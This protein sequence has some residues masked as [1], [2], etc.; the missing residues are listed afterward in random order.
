MT[1][2]P[3]RHGRGHI[4]LQSG[5]MLGPLGSLADVQGILVKRY[6]VEGVSRD[7]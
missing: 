5:R 1:Q 4:N 3:E 2:P 7:D 6:K